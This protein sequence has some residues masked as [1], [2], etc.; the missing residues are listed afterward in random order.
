M[1]KTSISLGQYVHHL[2]FIMQINSF[3]FRGFMSWK[4]PAYVRESLT[5]SIDNDT[6]VHHYSLA[7]IIT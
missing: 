6:S 1:P 3:L 5:H 4:P 2:S 7:F